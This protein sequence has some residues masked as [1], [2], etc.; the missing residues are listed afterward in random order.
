MKFRIKMM[1]RF[2]LCLFLVLSGPV[3]AEGFYI[4]GGISSVKLN[5]DHPS[6][7]DQS[8]TGYHLLVGTKS[9]NWGFEAAVTGGM[10]FN[11]G[12]TPGIYYTEDSADY[13]ILD[14][15][16]KRFFHP[17]SYQNLSPWVG[18]GLGLHFITWR[19]FYYNVDGY[20]YS[21]TG[22]IDYQIE[23]GWLVRGG[24][25][26]YGFTSDDTYDSGPYDGTTT[27]LNFAV[28]YMF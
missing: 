9:E 7:N 1:N 6:I 22:G 15:G 10:S 18:A 8:S 17:E 21:I 2:Y 25:V 20:G 24:M 14:L 19:T 4:G 26:Y 27:Q 28:I 16:V 11:T 3:H 23:P 13:G 12:P 5:S